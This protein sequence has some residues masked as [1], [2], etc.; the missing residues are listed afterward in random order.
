MQRKGHGR[1]PELR[2]DDGWVRGQFRNAF[3]RWQV[4]SWSWKAER[5]EIACSVQE[6]TWF[7]IAII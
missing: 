6:F 7:M 3:Q 5:R 4:L 2:K 1:N